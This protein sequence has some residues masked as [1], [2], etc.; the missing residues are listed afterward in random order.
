M[1]SWIIGSGFGRPYSS[2]LI[3][4]PHLG[5]IVVLDDMLIL[6]L[7]FGQ[8]ISLYMIFTPLISQNYVLNE[9]TKI[10]MRTIAA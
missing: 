7:Q 10:G 5:H 3:E 2:G 6:D 9:I 1:L 4:Y 8:M